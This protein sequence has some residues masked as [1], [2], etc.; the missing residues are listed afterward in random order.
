MPDLLPQMPASAV[1]SP[2]EAG[3][4]AHQLRARSA[5][6]DRTW[7]WFSVPRPGTLLLWIPAPGRSDALFWP[8]YIYL[9]KPTHRHTYKENLFEKRHFLNIYW[10]PVFM[11]MTEFDAQCYA[12]YFQKSLF[13]FPP[14]LHSLS[15]AGQELCLPASS[16]ECQDCVV[17]SPTL[18][19]K[20]SLP[21]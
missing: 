21:H 10:P 3:D 4:L 19:F 7:D 8:L 15:Q 17:C 6:S 20:F 14:I 2:C 5:P 11:Q 1:R 18:S 9:H 12:L 13:F 16:S